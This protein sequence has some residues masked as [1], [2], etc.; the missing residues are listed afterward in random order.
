[1]VAV[2]AAALVALVNPD[3]FRGTAAHAPSTSQNHPQVLKPFLTAKLEGPSTTLGFLGRKFREAVKITSG[4]QVL[5]KVE[6]TN[7]SD[8]LIRPDADVQVALS[9][10][11]DKGN[12]YGTNGPR[13]SYLFIRHS[14]KDASD[15]LF[16]G[17]IR[18]HKTVTRQLYVIVPKL[19]RAVT[20][21]CFRLHLLVGGVGHLSWR[22]DGVAEACE[23]VFHPK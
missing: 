8:E 13:Q 16:V 18:A 5:L 20:R 14:A 7:G 21:F 10:R 12:S 3:A 15:R 22:K 17:L 23:R 19:P 2:L 11:D 4:D 6:V 1:M 9:G